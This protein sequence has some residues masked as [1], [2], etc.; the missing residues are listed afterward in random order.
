MRY[1]LAVIFV[2]AIGMPAASALPNV[3]PNSISVSASKADPIVHVAKRTRASS[4]RRSRAGNGGI[5]P[6][7]GSGGY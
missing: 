4:S 6:L 7:V 5:H 3:N 1:V 2:C